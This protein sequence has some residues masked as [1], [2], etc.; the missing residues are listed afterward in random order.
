[1]VNTSNERASTEFFII[2]IINCIA[3]C[4]TVLCALGFPPPILPEPSPHGGFLH[5]VA[6]P[7]SNSVELLALEVFTK[8]EVQRFIVLVGSTISW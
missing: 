3:F 1:M 2:I 7:Q 8:H 4:D 5:L 6:L